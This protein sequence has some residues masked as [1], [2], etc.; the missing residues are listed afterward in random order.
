MLVGRVGVI[1]G[2]G[3]ELDVVEP[4]IEVAPPVVVLGETEVAEELAALA[5]HYC[6]GL[7]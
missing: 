1:V 4:V 7:C 3:V 6:V 5:R 2:A